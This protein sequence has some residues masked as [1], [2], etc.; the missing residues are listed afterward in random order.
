MSQTYF[1]ITINVTGVTGLLRVKSLPRNT[2]KAFHHLIFSHL[3]TPVTGLCARARV[4]KN[5]FNLLILISKAKN[6]FLT[7]EETTRNTRNTR[8]NLCFY[9]IF[10]L[11]TCNKT[12]FTR[13]KPVT[14]NKE[15]D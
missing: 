11:F 5:L 12:A 4:K 14:I 6:I 15:C 3:V 13:N 7:C 8:N 2:V 9:Y 10:N 1:K